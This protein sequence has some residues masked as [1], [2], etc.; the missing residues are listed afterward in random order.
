MHAFRSVTPPCLIASSA[1]CE[2]AAA[3]S[4]TTSTRECQ[5]FAAMRCCRDVACRYDLASTHQSLVG[6][7]AAPVRSVVHVAATGAC[8]VMARRMMSLSAGVLAS[9]SWDRTVK[10]WDT[11]ANHAVATANQPDKACRSLA[12]SITHSLTH[13]GV[14][15]GRGRGQHHRR[16]SLH[17]VSLLACCDGRHAG[18]APRV[19]LGCATHGNS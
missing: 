12:H 5:L 14:Y 10:L 2:C 17:H 3:A 13:S 18:G 9:G 16:H 19:D 4:R 1:L 8:V 7:H 11:R 6:S 15:H